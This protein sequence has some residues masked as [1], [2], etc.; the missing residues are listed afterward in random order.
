MLNSYHTDPSLTLSRHIPRF[1]LLPQS[2]IIIPHLLVSPRLCL[3]LTLLLPS[4]TPYYYIL[5][6]SSSL[7]LSL[8]PSLPLS[9]STFLPLSFLILSP[10]PHSHSLSPFLIPI[11]SLPVS[12]PSP[13]SLCLIPS[14][15]SLSSCPVPH[16]VP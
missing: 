14:S 5:S 8:P 10:L 15:L 1:H 11:L 2:C 16:S 6:L 7:P 4:H 13:L 9:L 3:H 12:F